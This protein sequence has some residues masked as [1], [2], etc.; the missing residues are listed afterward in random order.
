MG[1]AL[2]VIFVLFCLSACAT[3][4]QSGAGQPSLHLARTALGSG[5]PNL[6]LNAANEVLDRSPTNAEALEIKGDALAA[7]GRDDEAAQSYQAALTV[8]PASAS[9]RIGLGRAALATD[10]A[11]AERYF[12]ETLQHE[13]R[14]PIALN[15]LGI[16]LDLQ[17]RHA[18]AQKLYLQA[19]AIA[20]A[21][22]ASEVNLA[23]SMALSGR[24]EEGAQ[25][26][27]PRF[28]D[29]SA[30]PQM[31]ETMAAIAAMAQDRQTAEAL[32]RTQLSPEQIRDAVTQYERLGAISQ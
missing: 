6:A 29:A 2:S 17:S 18:E 27:R 30:S 7:L 21:M 1:R 19:L 4:E 16:A 25:M 11:L 9:A 12:V 15:D 8:D 26:M 5:V 20:P 32:L 22:Q 14:N 10:A 28:G 13:P 24:A 31:R 23:L 3:S